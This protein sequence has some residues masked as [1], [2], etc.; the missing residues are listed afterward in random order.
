MNNNI[1]N[2]NDKK[3]KES[4]IEEHI[5]KNEIENLEIKFHGLA[6]YLYNSDVNLRELEEFVLV[7]KL[8]MI[9]DYFEGELEAGNGEE[10][11]DKFLVDATEF[12]TEVGQ[13]LVEK[14]FLIAEKYTLPVSEV[15]S[16]SMQKLSDKLFAD[17]I[18]E[19]E[20]NN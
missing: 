4:K 6:E 7:N 18:I 16:I 9:S 13:E 15:I 2:F 10:L 14:A 11:V 1:I 5:I 8:A 3:N 19:F 17:E 12:A 20:K